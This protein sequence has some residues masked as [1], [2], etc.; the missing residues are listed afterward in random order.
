MIKYFLIKRKLKN[1]RIIVTAGGTIERIDPV[2][3][4]GNFSSGKMGIEIAKAF[5]KYSKNVFLIYGNVSYKIPKNIFAEKA[6]TPFEMFKKIKEYLTE[7]SIL[8]MSAAVSDFKVLKVHR[9][10]IK[11]KK[12]INLTLVP[13]IDILKELSKLKSEK[14]FFVG[15]A[16]ETENFIKNAKR[17][18]IE[19]K[20]DM[21]I[22][23]PID[24]ENYPFGSDYNKVFIIDKNSIIKLP[25][26]KKSFIAKIILKRIADEIK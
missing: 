4:I 21:I 2:R 5:R 1:R 9:K 20:L 16:V 3:F 19:K 14:N 25:K 24:K 17:K 15:F 7:D 10:K 8:I 13:E 11:K 22:L 6:L 12:R 23:N 26:E 18:L